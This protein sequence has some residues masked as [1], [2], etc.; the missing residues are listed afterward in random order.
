[1]RGEGPFHKVR[2]NRVSISAMTPELETG[3]NSSVNLVPAPLERNLGVL[4][5]H[6]GR[7]KPEYH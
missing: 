5:Q 2:G 6:S 1:M 4:G 3:W 7:A